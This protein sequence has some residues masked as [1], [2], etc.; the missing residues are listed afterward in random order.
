MK[1]HFFSTT[2]KHWATALLF[3][4]AAAFGTWT[5]Y[6][7][8]AEDCPTALIAG[9]NALRTSHGLPPYTPNPILMAVSQAHSDYQASIQT[10][11]HIGPDGSH[12]RDRVR[13]AGYGNG[14]TI[15]VSENIAWGY[16]QTPASVIQMWTGDQPHWNTM[17][18]P[19][20]RDIGAGCATDSRGATYYTIDAAYYIGEGSPPTVPPGGTPYPTAT[21]V[22]PVAPYIRATPN[23]DGSII[24]IVRYGQ[25]LSGIA[26]VYKVPIQ[27]LLRYNHLTLNSTLY[28][29]QKVIV[30]PPQITATPTTTPT[31]TPTPTAT[32]TA[33]PSP[34]ASASPTATATLWVPLSPTPGGTSTP[35]GDTTAPHSLVLLLGIVGGA[36]LMGMAY[37]GLQ[38]LVKWFG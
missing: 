26:Y 33:T 7:T 10:M 8:R 16:Y 35:A 28:V 25:T 2:W 1:R 21:V 37:I 23:A 9:V 36:L 29:G 30:R 13:A 11:T 5:A 38:F 22:L 34:T 27:D 15:F 31:I 3:A 6:Q 4:L 24:H 14:H 19:N 12:P 18:G 17:M 32:G 20:Y